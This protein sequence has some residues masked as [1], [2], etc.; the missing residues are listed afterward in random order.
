MSAMSTV[1]IV[2]PEKPAKR[3]R[4][5]PSVLTATL[6]ALRACGY[7]V[8]NVCVIGQRVEIGVAKVENPDSVE[9][10]SQEPLEWN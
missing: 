3:I 5:N 8:S 9:Q 7:A 4:G 1:H 6:E 2:E 10:D